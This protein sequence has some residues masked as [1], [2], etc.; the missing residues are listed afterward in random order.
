MEEEEDDEE[1]MDVEP[2]MDR[3]LME[4]N[5]DIN[6][7]QPL[8]FDHLQRTGH[9]AVKYKNMMIVWGGYKSGANVWPKYMPTTRFWLYDTILE[10]WQSV[11]TKQT[12]APVGL[13]GACGLI[14][15]DMLYIFGGYCD[16]RKSNSGNTN[17]ICGLDLKELAWHHFHCED[18]KPIPCDKMVGWTH[19]EGLYYFGGFGYPPSRSISDNA[20]T[21]PCSFCYDATDTLGVRRGWNN[22]LV[23]FDT[24]TKKW[25]WPS[26]KGTPP[27]PRAAHAAAKV[28]NKV[29]IFGGRN[30][31]TRM[32]DLHCLDL[33]NMK[34]SGRLQM[35]GEV[36]QGRSWHTFTPV[37]HNHI[38]LYGGFTNQNEALSDCW[39]LELSTLNWTQVVLPNDRP[40]LWHTACAGEPGSVIIFGG[41]TGNAMN[42]VPPNEAKELITLW[43]AP[44][45]LLRLCLDVV[46]VY[47][48]QL[49]M[50]WPSLPSALQEIL[51]IKAKDKDEEN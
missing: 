37:S 21:L 46:L 48:D 47:K 35:K 14:H 1:I 7:A 43:F 49:Q 25:K 9:V 36:P 22:Q 16:E 33:H 30:T 41:C 13:S 2:V 10:R 6:A 19:N 40:R 31:S 28:G 11:L 45:T 32:N 42:P 27:I 12:N 8:A 5:D 51:R 26:Y 15:G 17:E 39:I 20:E 23:M 38:V 3:I 29:Y 24:R 34:W 4:E 18:P 44:K 50:L